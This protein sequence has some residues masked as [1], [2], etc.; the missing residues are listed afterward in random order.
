MVRVR[1]SQNADTSA[2]L[3]F[4]K[5]SGDS[6][7]KPAVSLCSCRMSGHLFSWRFP[8]SCSGSQEPK[9]AQETWAF[10]MQRG[11]SLKTGL[12]GQGLGR[13]RMWGLNS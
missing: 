2:A 5:T 7:A 13:H 11:D 4:S 9:D 6:G 12:E 1:A 8:L 3:T 10:F